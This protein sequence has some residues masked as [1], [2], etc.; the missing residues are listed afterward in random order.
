MDEVTLTGD[1]AVLISRIRTIDR[2]LDALEARTL[3]M[4]KAGMRGGGA[5]G[6]GLLKM[7]EDRADE[8]HTRLLAERAELVQQLQRSVRGPQH[9]PALPSSTGDR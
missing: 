7:A 5:G 3:D 8:Q 4:V 1:D 6:A 2:E 9:A